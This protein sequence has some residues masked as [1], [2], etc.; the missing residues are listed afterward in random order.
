MTNVDA[1]HL[2]D[3]YIALWTEPDNALR[4][5]A[6][7]SLWAPDG[8]HV[9]HPPVAIREAADSLGFASGSLRACGHDAIERRV[10]RSYE[11]FVASGEYSFRSRQDAVRLEDVV[12]FSWEMVPVAGGEVVGGGVEFLV[13]DQDGQISADYMFP[14]L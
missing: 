14:G 12:K 1:Q 7:E 3:R 13:L 8:A 9:L 2:A 6:V 11:K 5:G 10:V 4:R